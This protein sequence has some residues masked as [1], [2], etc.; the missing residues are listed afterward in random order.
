MSNGRIAELTSR[1]VVAVS[2]LESAA[3]LDNLLT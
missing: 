3:L 2:G 1:G